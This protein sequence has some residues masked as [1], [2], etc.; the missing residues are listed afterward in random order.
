MRGQ[1]L[2]AREGG[3]RRGVR[4]QRAGDRYPLH[5]HTPTAL[6]RLDCLMIINTLKHLRSRGSERAPE[7]AGDERR[8][9]SGEGDVW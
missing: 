9:G 6:L 3:G 7:R 5:S 4:G 1:A 8:E 2:H